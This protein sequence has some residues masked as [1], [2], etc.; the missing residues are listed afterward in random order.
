VKVPAG[1]FDAI[2]IEYEGRFTRSDGGSYAK[3]TE[4]LW[5]A[6]A[7]ARAVKVRYAETDF[8]YRPFSEITTEL[9]AHTRP[10]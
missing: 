10:H 2:R 4:T 8:S 3:V 1:Q 5:W 9:T 6:P 7:A